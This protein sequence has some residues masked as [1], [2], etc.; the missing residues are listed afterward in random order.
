MAE[1]TVSSNVLFQ[2]LDGDIILLDMAHGVYFGLDEVGARMWTLLAESGDRATVL[3][4]MG[5]AY[6][7]DATT[8]CNDL[9]RLLAELLE[10]GLLQRSE[11]PEQ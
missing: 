10:A 4:Q 8:L 2:E 7:V 11:A 6:D 9:D 1:F 5:A 3:A